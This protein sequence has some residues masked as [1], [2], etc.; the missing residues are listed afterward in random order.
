MFSQPAKPNRA[1][2]RRRLLAADEALTHALSMVEEIVMAGKT[3][4]RRRDL[5]AE[6]AV[7]KIK[8]AKLWLFDARKTF[9]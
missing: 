9:G 7:T 3:G 6:R 5:R 2:L 1:N 4:E 8:N